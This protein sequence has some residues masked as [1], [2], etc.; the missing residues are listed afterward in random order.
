LS[1]TFHHRSSNST[2]NAA[3]FDGT[4]MRVSTVSI[5]INPLGARGSDVQNIFNDAAS[6]RSLI[7]M[8]RVD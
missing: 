1:D 3:A 4:I 2:G 6:R 8:Q 5:N 7:I